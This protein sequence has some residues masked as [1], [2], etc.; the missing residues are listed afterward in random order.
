M[1]GDYPNFPVPGEENGTVPFS[2][3]ILFDA[4]SVKI[5]R[6]NALQRRGLPCISSDLA[7]CAKGFVP[8]AVGS[9]NVDRRVVDSASKS[10][11]N[12]NLAVNRRSAAGW[13]L[14]TARWQK[15]GRNSGFPA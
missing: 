13:F 15:P 7:N 2:E 9:K 10:C 4:L 5:C 1:I 3:I 8:W 6:Q 14:A 12:A 11:E